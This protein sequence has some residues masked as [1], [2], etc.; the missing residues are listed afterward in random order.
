ME[1]LVALHKHWLIADSIMQFV[2]APIDKDSILPEESRQSVEMHSA[3]LRLLVLYSLIYVVIEGY[4]ELKMTN[5]KIDY[6]L[7]NREFVN[8]LKRLRNGTFHYQ[9]KPIPDKVMDFLEL[10]DSEIWINQ[11]HKSFGLFFHENLI[12]VKLEQMS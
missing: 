9:E 8:K 1:K 10:K 11:L 2:M 12:K 4:E 5:E 3:W 7:S 6:L